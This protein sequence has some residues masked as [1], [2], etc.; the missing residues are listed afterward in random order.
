MTTKAKLNKP[1]KSGSGATA[2][3]KSWMYYESLSFFDQYVSARKGQS[4]MT[5]VIE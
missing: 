1:A 4:N 5:Q 3:K 2:T